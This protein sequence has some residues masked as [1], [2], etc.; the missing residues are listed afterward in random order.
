M[1]P[2]LDDLEHLIVALALNAIAEPIL[3]RDSA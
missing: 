2:A 1:H 3:S